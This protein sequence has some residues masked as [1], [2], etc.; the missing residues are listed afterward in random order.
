M[1]RVAMITDYPDDEGVVDGGVQAVS[2]YLVK[3]MAQTGDIHVD[4]IGFRYGATKSETIRADGYTRHILPGGRFGAIT[5]YWQD[6]R[7]LNR[8]LKT[9]SPDIV[10]SQGV[11]HDGTVAARSGYPVVTTIHGIFSEE[12]KHIESF[13]RRTRHRLLDMLSEYHCIRHAKHTI[14]ISPYVGEHWG[15]KLSGQKYMIANP[16]APGFFDVS[17]NEENGRI[18]FAGRLYKLK[19][20]ADLISAVATVSGTMNAKLVL[21]GSLDDS[22]YVEFL[23]AETRRLG[24]EKRVEFAGILGEER[25]LDELSRAAVLVLPSYQETAPMV[26]QEA[27]AS[28]VPVIATRVGGT[29]Y[30][31]DDGESG[32]LVEA[33]D[34][35][36]L[37]DRLLRLFSDDQLRIDMGRAARE[38]ASDDYRAINV[39]KA[40]IDVYRKILARNQS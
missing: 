3:A 19:G 33:G 7:S 14:L 2:K 30:Q 9:I 38:R 21:A 37:A 22:D 4:V 28:G 31:I 25:L 24:V 8:L 27:M 18:L 1:L 6:Q 11:G 15:D 12:A 23:K 32:F 20:V 10:H 35:E 39:A 29:S 5:G 36:A 26:I 40:T 17:R 34:V 16:V 13:H